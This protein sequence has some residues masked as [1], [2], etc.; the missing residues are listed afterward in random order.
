MKKRQ[1]KKGKG[2]NRIVK[3]NLKRGTWLAWNGNYPAPV[4]ADVNPH[5]CQLVMGWD[6]DEP[7]GTNIGVITAPKGSLDPEWTRMDINYLSKRMDRYIRR[8]LA[9]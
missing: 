2:I 3:A 7:N 1:L 8:R 4:W 6:H 9:D 5:H